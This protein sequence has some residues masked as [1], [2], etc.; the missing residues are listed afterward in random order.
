MSKNLFARILVAVFALTLVSSMAFAQA[1]KKAAP[2]ASARLLQPE[3]RLRAAE[4]IEHHRN[5]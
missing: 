3:G 4:M 2:A 1:S 5:R